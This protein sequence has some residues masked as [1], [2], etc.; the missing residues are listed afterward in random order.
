MNDVEAM[1]VGMKGQGMAIDCELCVQA[2]SVKEFGVQDLDGYDIAF[3]QDLE[4]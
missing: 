4:D 3:G 2:Y 1:F